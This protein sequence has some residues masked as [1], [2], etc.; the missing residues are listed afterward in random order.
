[1]YNIVKSYDELFEKAVREKTGNLQPYLQQLSNS[2]AQSFGASI[3]SMR[4]EV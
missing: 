2:D 4:K 1:V 3:S